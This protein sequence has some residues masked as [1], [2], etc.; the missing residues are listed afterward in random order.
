MWVD[1]GEEVVGVFLRDTRGTGVVVG[2][3][4]ETRQNIGQLRVLTIPGLF[5][6]ME[7]SGERL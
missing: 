4:F 2:S 1:S 6:P 3:F 7:L 5:V